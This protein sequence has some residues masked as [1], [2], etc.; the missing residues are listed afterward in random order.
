MINDK[1]K[2]CTLIAHNRKGYDAHFILKWMVDQGM[3]PYCIYING[4]KIMFMEIQKLRIRFI[5]SLNFL[6]M[7]LKAFPKTFGLDRSLMGSWFG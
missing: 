5:D 1:F 3:K 7:P 2:E 4:A 6:Q